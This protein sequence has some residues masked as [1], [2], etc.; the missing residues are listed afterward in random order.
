[1]CVDFFLFGL[2]GEFRVFV[3]FT[4][5]LQNLHKGGK[6]SATTVKGRQSAAHTKTPPG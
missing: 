6:R 5:F 2:F 1:M 4:S 3:F